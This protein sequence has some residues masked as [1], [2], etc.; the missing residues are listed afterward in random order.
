MC[1]CLFWQ[2][3]ESIDAA[4]S[5]VLSKPWLP[6]PLGL[7]GPALDGVMGE[8]QRQGIPKIPPSCAWNPVWRPQNPNSTTS[9]FSS[10][11]S[12]PESASLFLVYTKRGEKNKYI[13]IT[14]GT[15]FFMYH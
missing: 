10:M 14:F 1:A 12:M 4:I 5:D 7:K 11:Y 13:Y 3:K 2:S 8:L 9:Q 15:F 6:L